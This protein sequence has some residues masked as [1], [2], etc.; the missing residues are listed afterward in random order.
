VIATIGMLLTHPYGLFVL[1]GQLLHLTIRLIRTHDR[2]GFK[3]WLGTETL[4]A[5]PFIPWLGFVVFNRYFIRTP[6]ETRWL[7]TAS[8]KNLRDIGLGYVGIPV[9]YPNGITVTDPTLR[10]G[11]ILVVILFGLLLWQLHSEWQ[12]EDDIRP[13]LLFGTVLI[14][15]IGIPFVISATVF[16]F[17]DVRYVIIG[18]VPLYILVAKSI[19][20][21]E[22]SKTRHFAL[23][24]VLLISGSMLPVFYGADT[25]EPWEEAAS[26]IEADDGNQ[27]VVTVPGYA[28]DSL[29]YYTGT[30]SS[31]KT[32]PSSSVEKLDQ[33]IA[34][35]DPESLWVVA[36]GSG[37]DYERIQ[38]SLPA[39]YSQTKSTSLGRIE[40]IRFQPNVTATTPANATEVAP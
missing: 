37:A 11:Q 26:T 18:L 5:I 10:I 25:Q 9:N 35:Y 28:E 20:D 31:V 7:S 22:S 33:Q 29:D 14:A 12:S 19:K 40:L 2:V 38:G 8:F 27:L 36:L 32:I 34:T 21:I 4:T 3:Q 13:I 24:F 6:S 16:P 30:D 17:F 1:L 15:L 23:I 39:V